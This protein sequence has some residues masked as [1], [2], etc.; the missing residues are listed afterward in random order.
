MISV[1]L[2]DIFF[3]IFFFFHFL[4][5]LHEKKKGVESRDAFT[6][7]SRALGVTLKWASRNCS[8]IFLVLEKNGKKDKKKKK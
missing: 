2:I 4:V 5:F 1:W 6:P 7:K 8:T 3:E